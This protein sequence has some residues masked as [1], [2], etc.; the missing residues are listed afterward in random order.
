MTGSHRL[1][2]I[3]VGGALSWLAGRTALCHRNECLG[4]LRASLHKNFVRRM[5]GSTIL[6]LSWQ[7]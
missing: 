4:S 6:L 3:Q 7:S 5:N 1:S 2:S